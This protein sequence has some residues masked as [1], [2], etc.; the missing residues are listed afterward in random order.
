MDAKTRRFPNGLKTLIRLRDRT[1]R[2]P[3]CDAPVRH[4]DHITPAHAD[5]NTSYQNGQGLCEACNQ[6]KETTGWTTQP[7][8]G[9]ERSAWGRGHAI[10]TPTGHRYASRPPAAPGH[11]RGSPHRC[12]EQFRIELAWTG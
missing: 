6:A 3:W 1:C 4:I 11:Q 5:G 2:T 7:L 8:P 9:H 10:V 12:I